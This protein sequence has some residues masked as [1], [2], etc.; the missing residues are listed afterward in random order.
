[1]VLSAVAAGAAVAMAQT[2]G[3]QQPAALWSIIN[4]PVCSTF[5]NGKRVWFENP[6]APIRQWRGD[7]VVGVSEARCLAML[8]MKREAYATVTRHFF[9][10]KD[11]R[12]QQ[13]KDQL[14]AVFLAL[15]PDVI[16]SEAVL[17]AK[18]E[19]I[20][21]TYDHFSQCVPRDTVDRAKGEAYGK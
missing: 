8:E 9:P 21:D 4:P 6:L 7:G 15:T 16:C 1:M 2:L 10:G 12:E 13:H 11:A 20:F 18:G 19:T 17:P 5:I 3:E 14:R